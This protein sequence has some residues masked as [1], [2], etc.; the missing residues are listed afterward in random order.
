[1]G[2][3]AGGTWRVGGRGLVR[4]GGVLAMS[5]S[6]TVEEAQQAASS[7]CRSGLAQRCP[8]CRLETRCVGLLCGRRNAFRVSPPKECF[9]ASEGMCQ[10][11]Q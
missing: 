11:A 10:S 1:M 9:D 3:L 8:V 4:G 6:M 5:M 2:E 7:Q